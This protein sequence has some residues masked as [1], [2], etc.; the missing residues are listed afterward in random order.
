MDKAG[1]SASG[2]SPH[3]STWLRL[4]GAL[5]LL[6]LA[7]ATAFTQQLRPEP[8]RAPSAWEWFRHPRERNAFLRAPVVDGR[9]NDAV[10]PEGSDHYW[11][12]GDGGIVL[13]SPD[14][15]ATWRRVILPDELAAAPAPP[16]AAASW[17]FPDL[18]S[19]AHAGEDPNAVKGPYASPAAPVPAAVETV[20]PDSP[21]QRPLDIAPLEQRAPEV[22]A[23]PV[24]EVAPSV[25]PHRTKRSWP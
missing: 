10:R 16:A 20:E 5:A 11:I 24:Q 2:A 21:E 15:G 1:A 9:L 12:V 7:L 14:L 23:E 4:G 17:R 3:L 6:A 22:V 25:R 18:V 13:H 8:L 19:E